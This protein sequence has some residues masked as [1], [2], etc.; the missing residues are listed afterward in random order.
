MHDINFTPEGILY[1]SM[2]FLEGEP[3]RD[4]I[5]RYRTE[6]RLP[7]IRYAV[8]YSEKDRLW[9]RTLF[10]ALQVRHHMRSMHA[11]PCSGDAY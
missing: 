7:D 4:I 8:V 1:I 10:P 11:A 9:L 5:R 3:L 6:R 2:E